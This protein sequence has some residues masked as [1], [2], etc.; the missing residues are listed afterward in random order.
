[1]QIKNINFTSNTQN[2][3]EV[4]PPV[5]RGVL[6][7][8]AKG[9][10]FVSS[11]KTKIGL[12]VATLG[13]VTALVFLLKGKLNVA[14]T[15]G[16]KEASAEL[17]ANPIKHIIDTP[18]DK[19]L[20]EFQDMFSKLKDLKGKDF[21]G[22]AYESMVKKMGYEGCAPRL[23]IEPLDVDNACFEG[24]HG[25][26]TFNENKLGKNTNEENLSIMFHEFTH[27]IQASDI[28]RTKKLGADKYMEWIP[29]SNLYQASNDEELCNVKFKKPYDKLSKDEIDNY[30][31]ECVNE[32]KQVFNYSFYQKIIDKK[33]IIASNSDLGKQANKYLEAL[34]QTIN[35]SAPL[36]AE[37]E[38]YRIVAH[39][40][41]FYSKLY[42]DYA[43]NHFEATAF[44]L[45]NKIK[46]IF[47]MFSA[48]NK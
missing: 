4:S 37:K 34:N 20:P 27:F 31:S 43:T 17:L 24:T 26:I 35:T 36:N 45:G 39:P 6:D 33:G 18:E 21:V 1:M 12:G 42:D 48:Q 30:V 23:K 25:V 7:D 5:K 13:L 32:L 15:N 8:N 22:K 44:T 41:E 38:G 9:D 47:D 29:K 3:I 16:I 28:I 19:L 40:L 11:N 14:K 2:I 46:K 10:S